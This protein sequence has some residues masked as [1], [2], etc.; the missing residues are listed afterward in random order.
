MAVTIHS[1][2]YKTIMDSREFTKGSLATRSELAASKKLWMESRTDAERYGLQVDA[3]GKLHSK[4]AIDAETYRRSIEKLNNEMKGG[5]ALKGGGLA[6]GVGGLLGQLGIGLSIGA[7]VS[8]LKDSIAAAEESIESEKRLGAVLAATGNTTGMTAQQIVD[9]SNKLRNLTGISDEAFTDSAAALASFGNIGGKVFKDAIGLAADLSRVFKSD[10]GAE[11]ENLGRALSNPIEAIARLRLGTEKLTAAEKELITSL[12]E[13]GDLAG[14]QAEIIRLGLEKVGGAAEA[15]RTPIQGLKSDIGEL[16]EEFGKLFTESAA[17]KGFVGMLSEGAR[18]TTKDVAT[19]RGNID[20]LG[21][22][23]EEGD[24]GFFKET[25]KNI[26]MDFVDETRRAFGGNVP[27]RAQF[28]PDAALEAAPEDKAAIAA[29]KAAADMDKLLA[30]GAAH[31]RDRE[32]AELRKEDEAKMRAVEKR[33]DKEFRDDMVFEEGAFKEAARDAAQDW[34]KEVREGQKLINEAEKDQR[35]RDDKEP[36]A[37]AMR[38]GSAEAFA[39][40]FNAAMG[41]R[42]TKDAKEEEKKTAENTKQ[43]ADAVR[44]VVPVLRELK[45]ALAKNMSAGF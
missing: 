14:A 23:I 18:A 28:I 10:L 2:V 45:D 3:L 22:G 12:A 8:A 33:L 41:G 26:L 44:D 4:N 27:E 43:T 9:Y 15:M 30:E 13:S 1:L 37:A 35:R 17:G 36:G 19:A 5:G 16:S 38:S 7:G 40:V 11:T 32:M 39:T 31:E 34:E 29:K 6:G 21:S 24:R 42:D 20:E 25:V